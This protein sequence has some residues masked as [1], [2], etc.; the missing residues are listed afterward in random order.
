MASR[1]LLPFFECWYNRERLH[2]TLG[3]VSPNT[4]EQDLTRCRRAA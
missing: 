2:S 3:C 4:F 1:A